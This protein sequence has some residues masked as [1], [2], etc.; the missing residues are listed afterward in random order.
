M[1][2]VTEAIS[3]TIMNSDETVTLDN[4]DMVVKGFIGWV[5]KDGS[6]V[7]MSIG[8]ADGTKNKSLASSYNTSKNTDI[9]N[10]KSLLAY[11]NGVLKIAGVVSDISVTGE[12]SFSFST[13]NAG[14]SCGGLVI[15]E[16][17]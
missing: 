4:Y 12:L 9:D 5:S 16:V 17:A 15:G 1:T 11:E 8:A 14:Y 3:F 13:L 10:T 7:K 2:L 6:D